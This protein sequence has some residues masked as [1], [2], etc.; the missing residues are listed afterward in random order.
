[1]YDVFLGIARKVELLQACF[2]KQGNINLRGKLMA[3]TLKPSNEPWMPYASSGME[4]NDD[5]EWQA[6]YFCYSNI[7]LLEQ[8]IQV[9][10]FEVITEEKNLLAFQL[11]L[12]TIILWQKIWR[13]LRKICMLTW[14]LT[15]TS[16]HVILKLFVR[17]F[18]FLSF[19]LALEV[20]LHF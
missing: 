20:F 17:C 2:N 5:D 13:T 3:L 1:M 10:I 9:I 16:F 8:F 7:V 18:A 12:P 14:G 11:I 19:L 6:S 4:K 15:A